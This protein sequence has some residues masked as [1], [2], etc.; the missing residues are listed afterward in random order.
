MELGAMRQENEHLLFYAP[1]RFFY[2]WKKWDRNA[3]FISVLIEVGKI[4]EIA[5]NKIGILCIKLVYL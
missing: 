5:S 1:L 2:T 4:K 3:R